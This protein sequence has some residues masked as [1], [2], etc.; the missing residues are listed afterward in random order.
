MKKMSIG[1]MAMAAGMLI[2]NAAYAGE[3]Q[4]RADNQE[5]RID[6]GVN[7]GQLTSKEAG[8]LEAGE[9]KIEANRKEA[10][11]DGK[12]T[13]KEHRKL[14]RQENRQSK[15]IHRAKHNAATAS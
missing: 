6:Q 11:S 1:L 4:N 7:S 13:A 9:A 2:V 8:K 15:R 14:N 3:V 10:L 5:K 12:M